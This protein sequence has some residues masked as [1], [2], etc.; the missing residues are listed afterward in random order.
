MVSTMETKELDK[1]MHMNM[2]QLEVEANASN[3]SKAQLKQNEKTFLAE[4]EHLKTELDKAAPGDEARIRAAIKTNDE[5]IVDNEKE[6][7]TLETKRRLIGLL[8]KGHL[9]SLPPSRTPSVLNGKEYETGTGTGEDDGELFSRIL[10]REDRLP[11]KMMGRVPEFTLK[12]DFELFLQKFRTYT[13]LNK[14]TE[15]NQSK[16]LLDTCL[17]DQAKQRCGYITALDEPYLSQT[18]K[19]YTDCLKLRFHPK[20]KSLLFKSTYDLIKQKNDQNIQD[21]MALKFSA[22]LRGYPSWP[23]EHFV[24]TMTEK[25]Y[26]EDLKIEIIRHLGTLETCKDTDVLDQQKRFSEVMQ[27]A[28]TALDLCRRT[29]SLSPE[30]MNKNGLSIESGGGESS[31]PVST[32][33]PTPT[34]AQAREDSLYE[35]GEWYGEEGEADYCWEAS[36]ESEEELPLTPQETEYCYKLETEQESNLWERQPTED[37]LAQIN[38]SPTKKLCFNC[39]SQNHLVA[40]CPT[41]LQIVRQRTQRIFTQSGRQASGGQRGLRGSVRGYTGRRFPG[42]GRGRPGYSGT[43]MSQPGRPWTGNMQSWSG[44]AQGFTPAARSGGSTNQA[45]YT[46]TNPYNPSQ[47]PAIVGP[48]PQTFFRS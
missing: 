12:E 33:S 45:R 41:R 34:V 44:N 46:H 23:F 40:Q 17:S 5:N 35:A 32:T 20:A 29:S 27:I 11:S 7:L 4:R 10:R 15:D 39:S 26:S 13:S 1:L 30:Q 6:L 24:R 42:G 14:I 43:R 21:Y 37:E 2:E 48:N 31:T 22:F 9:P 38:Q 3:L 18:F 8:K 19:E 28:N 16:L 25:L 47:A 36:P